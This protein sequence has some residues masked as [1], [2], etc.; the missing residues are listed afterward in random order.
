MEE[1]NCWCCNSK[2]KSS[3]VPFTQS[4]IHW[5]VECNPDFNITEFCSEIDWNT[6][7]Q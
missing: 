5:C 7:Y 2:L 1:N 4:R 6:I 3:E